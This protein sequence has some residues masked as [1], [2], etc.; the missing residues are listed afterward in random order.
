MVYFYFYENVSVLKMK[1]TKEPFVSG[2]VVITSALPFSSNN[3]QTLREAY[4]T[5]T[6]ERYDQPL[7]PLSD[8]DVFISPFSLPFL[9]ESSFIQS[10]KP[11]WMNIDTIHADVASFLL[12]T[13]DPNLSFDRIALGSQIPLRIGV[14]CASARMAFM[15]VMASYTDQRTMNSEFQRSDTP[16]SAPPAVYT[17]VDLRKYVTDLNTS[18]MK[19]DVDV[20]VDVD[21]IAYMKYRESDLSLIDISPPWIPSS[22]T[23]Q[24]Y[25]RYT[26]LR[27]NHVFRD[28]SFN[29]E[30]IQIR[31][32]TNPKTIK[33]KIITTNAM[34]FSIYIYYSKRSDASVQGF[35]RF[36]TKDLDDS[37]VPIEWFVDEEPIVGQLKPDKTPTFVIQTSQIISKKSEMVPFSNPNAVFTMIRIKYDDDDQR[38]LLN[39]MMPRMYDTVTVKGDSKLQHQL[40]YIYTK[41]VDTST[42]YVVALNAIMIP[43]ISTPITIDEN[44]NKMSQIRIPSDIQKTGIVRTGTVVYIEELQR[45]ATIVDVSTG[46]IWIDQGVKV[47]NIRATKLSDICYGDQQIKFRKDCLQKGHE[48]DKPCVHDTEC[49]FFHASSQQPG[50]GGCQQGFCELPL[51]AIRT[52]FRNFRYHEN[53]PLCEGCK[54]PTD[55]FDV[56]TCCDSQVPHA[57][58]VFEKI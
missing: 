9:R 39:G 48:W 24:E 19:K 51:G 3:W 49:P 20:D 11:V 41:H 10:K 1:S 46:K 56:Y 26:S 13:K 23:L 33:S 36:A 52:G 55:P 54:R 8:T 17:Y 12:F 15:G 32:S 47:D 58:Y 37:V 40:F 22:F 53:Q 38:G 29:F 34:T 42:T 43:Y 28:A 27:R 50:Q 6:L 14:T 57:K 4:P 25:E 2:D 31:V 18:I 30:P 16:E 7:F 44:G 5:Q 35:V 45:I 21:V